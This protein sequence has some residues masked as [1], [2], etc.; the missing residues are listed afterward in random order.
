MIDQFHFRLMRVVAVV[1][2][3]VLSG[4]LST[5]PKEDPTRFYTLSPLTLSEKAMGGDLDVVVLRLP[6]YLSG[7]K[8]AIRS[9]EHEIEYLEFDRWA[10][11]LDVMVG[12]RVENLLV[13]EG[14]S[15]LLKIEFVRFEAT[16]E[17]AVV[18]AAEWSFSPSGEAEKG[19]T[20]ETEGTWERS[21][22]TADMV[23]DLDRLL[24]AFAESVAAD[25]Q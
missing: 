4:C 18:I 22:S 8:I 19:G 23:D 15:G 3:L 25:L 2:M 10:E 20:F 16:A 21:A 17:G 5:E 9:G 7:R 24:D 1:S 12:E 14:L 13:H 11:P 6:Y